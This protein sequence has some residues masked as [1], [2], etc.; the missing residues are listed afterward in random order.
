MSDVNYLLIA[1]VAVIL[2][3]VIR[4]Y[5]KGFLRIAVSLAS[6]IF[7]VFLASKVSTIVGDFIIDRTPV[8][9]DVR[10][11]IVEIYAEKNGVLDNSVSDNQSLTIQSYELPELIASA[12]ITNN[13]QHMYNVLAASLF[14][15]YISG[16]LAKIV[17]KAGSFVGLFIV[18]AI[19]VFIILGVVKILEKIPVLR[20]LNRLSGMVAGL[21]VSLIFVW[22]FFTAA[23]IFFTNSIGTWM[24]IQIRSSQFLT[25]LF[26]N[27]LLLKIL[28]Q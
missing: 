10:H 20:T 28:L 19:F 24:F 22:V 27:N 6:L 18:F 14:E 17:I 26:N 23:M 8:Y 15:E 2:F 4:G 1:V 25:F 13:T 21:S 12:L 9:E 16:F 5:R 3:G 7:V 11:K